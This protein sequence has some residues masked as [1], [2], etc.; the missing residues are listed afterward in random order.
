M[1]AEMEGFDRLRAALLSRT[2]SVQDF[3]PVAEAAQGGGSSTKELLEGKEVE[4][5]P[6]KITLHCESV[7]GI[8]FEKDA[9]YKERGIQVNKVSHNTVLILVTIGTTQSMADH[10]IRS[11]KD[12]RPEPAEKK[13]TEIKP[14]PQFS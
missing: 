8:G 13:L 7:S 11:L 1:Q 4:L 6:L 14:I 10:L 5:D 3:L 12:W 2:G 9:L